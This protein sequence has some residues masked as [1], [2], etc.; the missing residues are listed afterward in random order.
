MFYANATL[1]ICVLVLEFIQRFIVG[2]LRNRMNLVMPKYNEEKA[3]Q[4]AAFL[5]QQSDCRMGLLKHTKIMY[6]IQREA[7]ERWSFPITYDPIYSM[8]DGQVLSET[9][10]NTKPEN[11]RAFWDKYIDTDRSKNI[12]SLRKSCPTGQLCRAEMSLIKEIYNRDK[13]KTLDQLLK[14]HHDYP[15]WTDPGESSIPTDYAKLLKVLGKTPEQISSFKN[16]MRSE[17]FLAGLA[18]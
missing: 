4:M 2:E 18:L 3:T 5:L 14:E 11:H 6:N 10:D 1:T 8:P 9:Y 13:D 15:E 16:D 7:I 17:A 12:V